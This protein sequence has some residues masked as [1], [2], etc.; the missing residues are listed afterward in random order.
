MKTYSAK[1]SEI[2]RK[3]YL[4][5]AQDLVLGR[6]ASQ[7]AKI[8]RGKHKPTYTPNLDCGDNVIVVNADKVHLTGMKR[9]N[10]T[11]YRHTGYP[12]GIRSTTADKVLNGE[13]PERV[14]IKAVERMIT[15]NPLGRQQMKKLHVYSG[16]EHPHEA[17]KPEKLDVASWNI[18]NNRVREGANEG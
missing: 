14:F 1:L 7:I 2:E 15:R 9:P 6:A 16:S 13:H 3:W 11:Y 17:Q 18:K 10:K 5:D 8:L 4:V 12:G